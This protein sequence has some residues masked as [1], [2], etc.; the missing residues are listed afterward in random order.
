VCE[1]RTYKL[2]F[3]CSLIIHEGSIID[4]TFVTVSKKHTTKKD[5]ESLKNSE[6][7]KD[8][9]KKVEE[10]KTKGEIKNKEHVLSQVDTDARWTKK[11]DKCFFGYK[12]HV[13]CGSKSELITAFA[14]TDASVNNSQVFVNLIL[15]ILRC[16]WLGFCSH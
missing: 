11:R 9:L 6:K 4:A 13:K 14:I 16:L 12:N 15:K 7:P 8:L 1:H 3:N 2:F 5:D 10:K